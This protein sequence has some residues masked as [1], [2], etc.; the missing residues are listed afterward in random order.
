MYMRYYL[1]PSETFVYR[2][3]QGVSS[4][5][6]PIVLTSRAINLDRFPYEDMFICERNFFEKAALR[7]LRSLTGR[8]AALAPRQTRC[9]QQALVQHGVALLH[10]HFGHFALDVLPMA[11]ALGIPMLVTFHGYDASTLLRN[12]RYVREVRGLV[13][14]AHAIIVSH[15]MVKRLAAVDI[16]P[17][18]FDVHYIGVPVEDFEF[19]ERVPLREKLSRG[20]PLQL[21]QVSNFHEV[22][23]HK[24]TVEMFSKYLAKHPGSRLVLAGDGPFRASI[25]ALCSEVGLRDKVD[26]PGRVAKPQVIDL[27]R[28]SHVFVQHSVTLPNG[29]MEGLP[30]V[31]M[32][33]MAMGM[34]VVSTIHSGIPELVDDGIDGFLVRERDVD[35]YLQTIEALA[36]ADPDTGRRA[37]KKIEARFNMAVQ[38]EKLIDIYQKAMEK[39]GA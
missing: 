39:T 26:F 3:L 25:E 16:V 37:R 36:D 29:T 15:N 13:E 7:M 4:A 22:K 1:A 11:K 20:E 2:Q 32:E 5:F 24:Y 33:A 12:D 30:T 6:H 8:F 28:N 17:R 35:D 34:T 10:A 38:N 21:L 14:Y 9:W 18:R 31:I 23:G 19:V 27:M